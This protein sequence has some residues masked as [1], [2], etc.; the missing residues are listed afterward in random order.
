MLVDHADAGQEIL[1][2]DAPYCL[3]VMNPDFPQRLLFFD[4]LICFHA[5]KVKSQKPYKTQLL[6]LYNTYTK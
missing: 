5:T 1:Q 2:V 6:L 3:V 4:V